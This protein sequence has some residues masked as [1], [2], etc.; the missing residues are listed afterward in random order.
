MQYPLDDDA[1]DDPFQRMHEGHESFMKSKAEMV[2]GRDG[3]LQKVRACV[4]VCVR[5]IVQR[6]SSSAVV[7]EEQGAR[8]LAVCVRTTVG[9]FHSVCLCV[10][11]C[12]R[13]CVC[14]WSGDI[15]L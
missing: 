14:V 13:V 4:C 3:I 12:V 7:C 2:L 10:C 5:V 6:P 8:D 9:S 1:E 15:A 11:V